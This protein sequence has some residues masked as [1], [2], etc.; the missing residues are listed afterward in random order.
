MKAIVVFESY[1]GN[2][3]AVARAVAEGIGVGARVL[4]T[5]EATGAI[6]AEADLIVAGSPVIAFSLPNEKMRESIRINP[7]KAPAPPDL[8]H[9]SLRSWLDRLPQ[10]H[11]RAAAFETRVKRSPGGSTS[12]IIEK[13]ENA[14]YAPVGEAGRFIVKGKFGPLAEGELDRA[15]EW[16]AALAKMME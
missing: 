14:G 12:K 7:G 11:G 4:T 10:G 8:S 16:G 5:S 13:L 3:A 15:R 1:W 9:P 2:T 6:L